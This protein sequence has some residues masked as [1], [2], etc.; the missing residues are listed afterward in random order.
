ME[1]SK[2]DLYAVYDTKIKKIIKNQYLQKKCAKDKR[3]LLNKEA[4]LDSRFIVIR[5]KDH[6]RGPSNVINEVRKVS[7]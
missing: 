3:N 7:Y 4:G 5:G 2:K 6:D 1:E